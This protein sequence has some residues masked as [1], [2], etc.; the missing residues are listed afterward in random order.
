[1][2]QSI[3]KFQLNAI[4]QNTQNIEESEFLITPNKILEIRINKLGRTTR[5]LKERYFLNDHFLGMI[6]D[7]E[8]WPELNPTDPE[9]ILAAESG[10]KLL[11]ENMRLQRSEDAK[12][13][14]LNKKPTNAKLNLDDIKII[15]SLQEKYSN[16]EL[17]QMFNVNPETIRIIRNN[18]SWKDVE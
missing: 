16:K 5:Q 12:Q 2:L 3:N 10:K 11:K 6:C 18:E 17:G 7:L 4:S 1:M 15:R 14:M 8:N 13:L 9:Q